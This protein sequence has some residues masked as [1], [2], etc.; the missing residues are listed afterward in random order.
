MTITFYSDVRLS[1]VI[2]R[3]APNWKRKLVPNSNDNNF[4]L[5]VRL[6]PVIYQDARNWKH[7]HWANSNDKN[8]LLGCLI[9]S[10]HISR[11]SKLSTEAPSKFKWQYLFNSDIRLSSVIYQDPRNWKQR[12]WANSKYNNVFL[13]CLIES[14]KISRRSK[15]KVE[16]MR[17]FKRQ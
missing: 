9:E 5:V 2:Y 11:C 7:R 14:R 12:H 3:G 8:V 15:M 4:H 16:A 17:K 6:S 1:P 13:G 10:H